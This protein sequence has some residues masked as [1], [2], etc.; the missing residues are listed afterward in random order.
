MS[1]ASG[2]GF[3]LL[4]LKTLT[5]GKKNAL[6]LSINNVHVFSTKVLIEAI[7]LRLLILETGPPFFVVIRAT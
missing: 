6:Y 1:S 5:V 7:L 3:F 2:K 4:N